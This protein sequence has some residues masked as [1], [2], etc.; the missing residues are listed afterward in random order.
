MAPPRTVGAHGEQEQ[1]GAGAQPVP[2]LQA[3]LLAFPL[4]RAHVQSPVD[5]LWGTPEV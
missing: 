2:L 1:S 4:L 3:Q 5:F